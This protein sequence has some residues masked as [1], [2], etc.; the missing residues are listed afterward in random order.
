M[1][2]ALQY[3]FL[4]A[5]SET[6]KNTE[7]RV[8][9]WKC[10]WC[11]QTRECKKEEKN[12][13]CPQRE[14]VLAIG[15]WQRSREPSARGTILSCDDAMMPRV[16][17]DTRGTLM[18]RKDENCQL[19]PWLIYSNFN[20][21]HLVQ[22]THITHT[23]H[24]AIADIHPSIRMQS[25]EYRKWKNNTRFTLSAKNNTSN[26]LGIWL[27]GLI[28]SQNTYIIFIHSTIHITGHTNQRYRLLLNQSS[29]TLDI[30]W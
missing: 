20:C 9:K 2:N 11:D 24:L 4:L 18:A 6:K 19:Y 26:A 17:D 5:C 1:N 21:F 25:S 7:I 23:Q 8:Y 14:R 27:L 13:L 3:K 29:S 15:G 12:L 10:F 22:Q 30:I 16:S 28:Q